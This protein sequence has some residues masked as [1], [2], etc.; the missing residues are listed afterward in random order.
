MYTTDKAK[1]IYREIQEIEKNWISILLDNINNDKR[2]EFEET[3]KKIAKNSID[4]LGK[5]KEEF[6]EKN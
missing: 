6:D 4:Y 1:K 2:A 5:N 3:I